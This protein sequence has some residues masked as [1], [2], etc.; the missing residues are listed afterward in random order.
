MASGVVRIDARGMRCPWPAMR[1]ART[2][3][4]AGEGSGS[5][6]MPAAVR[7]EVRA[8][9]PRAPTELA[10]VAA[11]AGADMAIIS[12]PVAPIFVVTRGSD[13]NNVFTE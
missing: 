8:D 6:E 4:Q 13:S 1:L 7:I 10:A 5:D 11:A 2:L 9:D 12:D 3:R